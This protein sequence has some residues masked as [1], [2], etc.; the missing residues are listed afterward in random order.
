MYKYIFCDLDGTLLDDQRKISSENI[1]AI[2]QAKEAK[3]TFAPCTGRLPY[4]FI[5]YIKPLKFTDYISTNGAIVVHD[6]KSI[7]TISMYKNDALK[8]INYAKENALNTR[9]FTLD[10]LYILNNTDAMWQ[11]EKQKEVDFEELLKVLE[12]KEVIKIGFVLD[13]NNT[14]VAEDI[15]N[16]NLDVEITYS[17][18]IFLEINSKGVD[19]GMGIKKYCEKLN[20]NVDEVIGIGDNGNDIPMLKAVGFPCCPNNAIDEVKKI[21][22]YISP[23]TNSESAIADIINNCVLNNIDENKK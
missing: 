5:D 17:S 3:V 9:V 16:M 14:K 19:K 23:Y 11:Y 22:K 4:C 21:C 12:K 2:E 13:K 7:Q 10:Y 18:D 15:A 6:N 20:I 8:I 1:Q